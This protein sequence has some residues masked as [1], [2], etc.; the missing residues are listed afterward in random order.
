MLGGFAYA[1]LS[2]PLCY[3]AMTKRFFSPMPAVIALQV[4]GLLVV[5]WARVTFGMRSF[6]V[7]SNATKG[8]LVTTG[9]YRFVR[10][11]IYAG[12]LVMLAGVLVGHH[13]V[14]AIVAVACV[15]V[16]LVV[17]M[18]AEER[19]VVLAYPEYAGYAARTKRIIPW[20]L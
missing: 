11:P 1:L 15:A 18:V 16:G 20:I 2:I 5:V 17:R 14:A 4:A 9:P 7:G 10:H 6:H 13:D 8:G 3:L 19:A 12:L